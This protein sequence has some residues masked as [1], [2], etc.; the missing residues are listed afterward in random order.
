MR[1]TPPL[2]AVLT[3]DPTTLTYNFNSIDTLLESDLSLSIPSS[4]QDDIIAH[5]PLQVNVRANAAALIEQLFLSVQDK[6]VVIDPE[7]LPD[8]LNDDY[9]LSTFYQ[10]L[11]NYA[12]LIEMS[13]VQGPP[14]NVIFKDTRRFRMQKELVQ[15]S[16]YYIDTA[17]LLEHADPIGAYYSELWIDYM[18]SKTENRTRFLVTH[19]ER[20][21]LF[22]HSMGFVNESIPNDINIYPLHSICV[23]FHESG[24]CVTAMK[25]RLF[26]NGRLGP[27][28]DVYT[29]WK[30]TLQEYNER[31][32][33]VADMISYPL[34]PLYEPVRV[35]WIK[36]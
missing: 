20:I 6:I 22:L 28:F 1:P 24:V 12:S 18:N 8:V 32:Q 33:I 30:G 36:E 15:K 17:I 7:T 10:N 26:E 9:Q 31:A 25:P 4:E 2:V 34:N 19:E 5:S 23:A 35:N 27:S 29:I 16:V 13:A 21:L 14:L 11:Y 3:T